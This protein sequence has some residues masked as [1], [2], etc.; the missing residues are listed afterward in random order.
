MDILRTYE[1][2]C[3]DSGIQFEDIHSIKSPD[4]STLFCSAGMQRFKD[5]F[6]SDF[7]GT[8]STNQKCL[9]VDDI[10]T[11]GDG[12][13]FGVFNMLGLFSFREWSITKSI[14]FWLDFMKILGL[15]LSEV[16][17][18]PDKVEW[19]EIYKNYDKNIKVVYDS[20]CRWSDG[21]IGGYC[22]EF[23]VDGIEIGN[24][25]NPL[26]TCIDVGFGLERLEQLVNKTKSKTKEEL[27]ISTCESI[28]ESGYKPSNKKQGYVLRKILRELN[29]I[30]SLVDSQLPH[31]VITGSSK[32]FG[33]YL[34]EER[35]RQDSIIKRYDKLKDKFPNQTK[36]W[37]FE[38]FGIEL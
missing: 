3:I 2:Y 29:K 19:S 35:D 28:I 33:T 6:K 18:H 12:T 5:K 32:E 9:R 31:L 20:E 11:I 23:Y 7:I 21:E 1:K 25:V 34:L 30:P 22:T 14:Y 4:N 15:E 10:N 38:T 36:E 27:L 17:I 16:H 13:H 37:W 24:I 8:L 26:E